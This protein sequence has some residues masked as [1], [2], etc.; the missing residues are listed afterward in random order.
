MGTIAGDYLTEIN[1]TDR[2]LGEFIEELETSGLLDDSILVVYG[3]HFGLPDPQTAEERAALTELLGHE[4]TPVDRLNTPLIVRLPG[5]SSGHKV[6]TPVGQVDLAPSL[7]DAL[8]VDLSGS[9]HFGRSI[10]SLSPVL[11]EAGGL[12]PLGSYV[13]DTMLYVAGDTFANGT[14]WSIAERRAV[15]PPATGEAKYQAVKELLELSDSH[16]RQ[17][18]TRDDFDPN[19]KV[20]L[21]TQ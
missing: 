20:I 12:L 13:D 17:L 16:V 1:Y 8:G 15:Q 7:A 3:D 6:A 18:P 4:Y 10:F 2:A 14:A 19:A 21:P 5:Q 9:A 11:F